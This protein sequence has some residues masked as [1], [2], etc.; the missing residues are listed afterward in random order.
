M[1]RSSY[2]KLFFLSAAAVTS[3]QPAFAGLSDMV[4]NFFT[5]REEQ[6]DLIRPNYTLPPK[7]VLV[8]YYDEGAAQKWSNY[9]T[10]DDLAP[11]VGMD[12]STRV[13][14][15]R[16]H[17]PEPMQAA[18]AQGQ[19]RLNTQDRPFTGQTDR[20]ANNQPQALG[21]EA[22]ARRDHMNRMN[23]LD[24]NVY[25]GEPGANP[26]VDYNA[27]SNV[28]KKVEIGEPK[29][30]WNATTPDG[31][32]TSHPGD[33]DHNGN[34]DINAPRETYSHNSGYE[35]GVSTSRVSGY[36]TQI[37]TQ[38]AETTSG[39]RTFA[40]MQPQPVQRPDLPTEYVVRP[41]DTLSGISD[42]DRIYGDWKMWPI[43][44]DANR[45]QINDPDLIQPQQRLGIPRD[46]NDNTVQ[47]ARTRAENKQAPYNFY[48]GK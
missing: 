31:Y 33:Y 10:R 7:H 22:I 40:N 9:Y 30:P 1:K 8:P 18:S 23:N 38:Y 20:L 3:A 16:T 4:N 29:R 46:Y 21:F 32:A 12:D 17:I 36:N 27:G 42:K 26:A 41:N 28:G 14:R 2:T 6:K 45:T 39:N 48:D 47:N 43:I 5:F 44:Y 25:I 19:S 11:S 35:T 15:P 24:G 37:N 34:I 13:M